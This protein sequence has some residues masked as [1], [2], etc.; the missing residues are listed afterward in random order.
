MPYPEFFVA[1]MR[2]ELR[3]LGIRER[4]TA[5]EWL[6]KPMSVYEVHLGSWR[7]KSLEE[8]LSYRELAAP[9]IDYVK[10]MGFTHIEFM[11]VAEHA[12]YPSWGYQVTGFFAPTSRYGTPEEYFSGLAW[13]IIGAHPPGLSGGYFGHWRYRPDNEPK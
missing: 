8:S 2:Q 7:K 13:K 12:F 1:P 3:D 4:R 11:P 9:L 6:R 10:D 5:E